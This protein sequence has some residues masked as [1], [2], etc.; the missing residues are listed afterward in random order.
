MWSKCRQKVIRVHDDVD[1]SVE[2]AEEGGMAAGGEFNA[3]PHRHRHDTVVDHMKSG[4]L[5]VLF[6][7]N[8]EELQIEVDISFRYPKRASH[9]L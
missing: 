8:E 6:A 2:E 1:E 7:E 9:S 4:D 5:V 3:K